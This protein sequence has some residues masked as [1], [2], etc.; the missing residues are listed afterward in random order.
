[1]NI[2][3]PEQRVLHALAQGGCIRLIRDERGRIEQID[4]ITREGYRLATCG[5]DMFSRL[6]RRRLIASRDGQPYRISR[7]G[8]AAVRAQLD[9][10]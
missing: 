1:M 4:C 5:R 7:E 6:K 10:R 2:S 9:N 8:L 3:K